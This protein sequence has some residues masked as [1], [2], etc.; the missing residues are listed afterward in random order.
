MKAA[1]PSEDSKMVSG[2]KKRAAEEK[3]KGVNS[4]VKVCLCVC[5]QSELL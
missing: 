5:G 4:E 3:S 1:G 2:G